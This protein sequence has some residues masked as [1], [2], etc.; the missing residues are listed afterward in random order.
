[1]PS[2]DADMIEHAARRGRVV[3]SDGAGNDVEV[4]LICWR[5]RKTGVKPRGGRTFHARIEFDNG[6]KRT[7]SAADIHP[8]KAPT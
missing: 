8:V 2:V 3:W 4:T 6:R 7:V 1:M 5:P